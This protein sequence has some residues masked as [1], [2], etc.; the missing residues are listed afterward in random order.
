[1]RS[2]KGSLQSGGIVKKFFCSL[3][4]KSS[5]TIGSSESAL[6][7]IL[8]CKKVQ[9]I[10]SISNLLQDVEQAIRNRISHL[11]NMLL[12]S[13]G[14]SLAQSLRESLVL[15]LAVSLAESKLSLLEPRLS[16]SR[17]SSIR[18]TANLSASC[19][20]GG[21][22]KVENNEDADAFAIA[23]WEIEDSTSEGGAENA[24]RVSPSPED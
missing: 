15:T 23:E 11:M 19:Q 5:T 21:R 7:K 12:L 6:I 24:E 3:N 9:S 14:V 18:A 13:L 20:R 16:V 1:M 8:T 4:A 10:R 2:P 22:V 17:M